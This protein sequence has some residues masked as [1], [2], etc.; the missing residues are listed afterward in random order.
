MF[1]HVQ[2]CM[3]LLHTVP[4]KAPYQCKFSA[5]VNLGC[6]QQLFQGLILRISK[7]TV[8]S[9]SK[10]LRNYPALCC[11]L[12]RL[13]SSW[14]KGSEMTRAHRKQFLPATVTF[15]YS[16]V[17]NTVFSLGFLQLYLL[18]LLYRV[19]T[20]QPQL[21]PIPGQFNDELQNKAYFSYFS[22]KIWE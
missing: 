10:V 21:S 17:S 19:Q 1:C 15:F 13:P 22:E 14:E 9:S 12:S 11:L 18:S 2:N 8:S 4:N 20:V 5:T 6:H 7:Y 3:Y 16:N